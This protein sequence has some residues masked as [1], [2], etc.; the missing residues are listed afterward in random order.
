MPTS[1]AVGVALVREGLSKDQHL[2]EVRR[3]VR[4][5]LSPGRALRTAP[6]AVACFDAELGDLVRQYLGEN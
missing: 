2:K 1:L 4:K 5:A 3:L 6:P